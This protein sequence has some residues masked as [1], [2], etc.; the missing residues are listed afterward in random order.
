MDPLCWGWRKLSEQLRASWREGDEGPG[1]VHREPAALDREF[2][3]R[4][5]LG[6]AAEVAEQKR[7]V[8]YLDVDA[9]LNRLDRIGDF[10]DPARGFFRVGIGARVD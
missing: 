5:V 8:D 4:A 9:S 6:R 3:A 7:L 2:E 1:F 10:E